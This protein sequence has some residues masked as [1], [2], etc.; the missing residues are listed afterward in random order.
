MPNTLHMLGEVIVEVTNIFSLGFEMQMLDII[1]TPRV[2]YT[3]ETIKRE[4]EKKYFDEFTKSQM[5]WHLLY[6][7]P[8]NQVCVL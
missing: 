7:I 4:R 3:Y 5:F 1:G 2:A 8:H 6:I